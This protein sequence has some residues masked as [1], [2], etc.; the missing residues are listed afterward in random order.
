M[1]RLLTFE[2][3]PVRPARGPAPRLRPG[4]EVYLCKTEG[5]G[6]LLV[7]TSTSGDSVGTH[8]TFDTYEEGM[9]Y[10]RV[11]AYRLGA[12]FRPH[13]GGR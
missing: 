8:E 6:W 7:D 1:G 13:E 9:P 4:A 10:A 5:G 2:P 12:T 3:K 11:L